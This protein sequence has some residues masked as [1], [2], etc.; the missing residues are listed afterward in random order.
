M[1]NDIN[2]LTIKIK[3]ITNGGNIKAFAEIKFSSGLVIKGFRIMSSPTKNA[4]FV[5][6]P[7]LIDANRKYHK[8][9]WFEDKNWWYKIQEKIL[10]EYGMAGGQE[11]PDEEINLN[12]LPF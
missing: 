7:A 8:L 4:I 2:K 9:V 3:T 11:K 10:A 12:D 1:D 5:D 6:A